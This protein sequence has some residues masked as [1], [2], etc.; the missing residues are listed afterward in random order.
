MTVITNRN[1]NRIPIPNHA[2]I[3]K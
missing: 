2:T 3:S 1:T